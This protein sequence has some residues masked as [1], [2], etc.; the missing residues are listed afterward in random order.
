MEKQNGLPTLSNII[1]NVETKQTSTNK[2]E[3]Q[4]VE[5]EA[6]VQ[7]YSS[8]QEYDSYRNPQITSRGKLDMLEKL[9]PILEVLVAK[10]KGKRP[11]SVSSNRAKLMHEL[12]RLMGPHQFGEVDMRD[13]YGGLP[14]DHFLFTS[15][16]IGLA[17]LESLNFAKM[18]EMISLEDIIE[19]DTIIELVRQ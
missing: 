16:L 2:L 17:Q 11:V 7:K 10:I 8:S 14:P 5:Q 18:N 15:N 6:I 4:Q 1:Q 19:R 12:Q 13:L 3:Q 9:I